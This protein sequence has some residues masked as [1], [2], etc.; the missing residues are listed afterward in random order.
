VAL[1]ARAT[2]WFERLTS[3]QASSVAQIAQAESVTTAYVTRVTH[4]ALLAPDIVQSIVRGEHPPALNADRLTRQ[5]PLPMDW[6]EQR[7]LLGF[8]R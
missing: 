4:L 7:A 3:G 5:V 6:T 2:D 1:L 8:D